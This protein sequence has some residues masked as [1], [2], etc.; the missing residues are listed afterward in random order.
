MSF[1]N[2]T[3]LKSF[4]GD[5]SYLVR[6]EA[7]DGLDEAIAQADQI[8]RNYTN[9]TI[10]DDPAEADAILRN[11]ACSLVIWYTTGM[12]ADITEQEYSRRK[13]M[14]LEAMKMLDGI[15]SGAIRLREDDEEEGDY[16]PPMFNSTQRITEMF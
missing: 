8:I 15:K 7:P 11:I 13:T 4:L 1:C 9:E 16:D 3:T 5:N 2:V 14:Y 10:P 12:Q 6:G